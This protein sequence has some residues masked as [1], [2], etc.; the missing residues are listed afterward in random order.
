MTSVITQQRGVPGRLGSMSDGSTRDQHRGS[1]YK[2]R[3]GGIMGAAT[4][5]GLHSSEPPLRDFFVSRCHKM[6]GI[7]EM[8]NF[9]KNNK[10]SST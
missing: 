5:G 1:G 2:R 6:D 7:E 4:S 9:L 3:S 8:H 10:Y